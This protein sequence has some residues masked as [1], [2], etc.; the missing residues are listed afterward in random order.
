MPDIAWQIEHSVVANASLAVVWNFW[1]NTGNWVDPPARFELNGPFA[2][3]STGRT[4]LPGQ[5][6]LEWF[7]REA[8]EPTAAIIEMPLDGA[9]LSFEWT[10]TSLSD[11]Q[12]RLTQRIVLRGEHAS[13]F[14]AQVEAGFASNLVDGM[15]RIASLIESH[16]R[17]APPKSAR[18]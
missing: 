11:E 13:N 16:R 6:P 5:P 4:H 17:P 10:F 2:A 14:I 15:K 1:T 7:I 12:T 18:L 8:S 3:G 9:S